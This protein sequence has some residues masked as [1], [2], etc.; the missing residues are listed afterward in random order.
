MNDS[1]IPVAVIGSGNIGVDLCERLLRDPDFELIALVGRR[2]TSPG[3]ARLQA[4]IPYVLSGGMD[5]FL[6]LSDHVS[7]V[8]DATSAF[9]HQSH[10]DELRALGK[11]MVDLTPSRIGQPLVPVLVGKSDSMKIDGVN[12]VAN[13]SMVT[14]G[15]QSCAPLLYAIA[16]HSKGIKEVEISSSIASLS[17][18]PATRL[19]VDQYIESTEEL[20]RIVTGCHEVKAILVLNPADP[21]VMMRTTVIIE[22]EYFD[23]DSIAAETKKIVAA[24]QS[25]VPGY[26][27]VVA[28]YAMTSNRVVATALVKGAGY[29]LPEYAGNLDIINAA[30]VETA[31]RH[32]N[33]IKANAV[34]STL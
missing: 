12:R 9:A 3:L 23:L 18:G 2:S 26:E 21:P 22:A 7:G 4:R 10:W 29:Y 28:P 13:Y 24:V 17:A 25:S 27:V 19:N 33:A 14:C 32:S 6:L 11:W 20:A 5:E 8:F 1:K 30:A 31:R 15:G 16:N 34:G